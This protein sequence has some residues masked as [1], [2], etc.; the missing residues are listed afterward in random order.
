MTSQAD[1]RR[2]A[3]SFPGAQEEEGRFAF[4]VEHKG[5]RKAFAWVWLERIHPK[6]ARVPNPSVV[7][8]RVPSLTDKELLIA[9]EPVKY[10]TEP[11]YNGYPA[12]LVRLAAVKVSD[13]RP[14]LED[15]WR[16]QAPR[17]LTKRPATARG[18]AKPKRAKQTSV[19]VKRSKQA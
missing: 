19:G 9:N 3:L 14:L 1:V 2:L 11:H 7:A 17:E 12:V 13:L 16:C 8:I 15:A 4:F 5:K 6:Q 18:G 10:F